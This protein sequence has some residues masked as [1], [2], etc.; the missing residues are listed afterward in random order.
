M[1][2]YAKITQILQAQKDEL[3]EKM[4]AQMSQDDI[5]LSGDESDQVQGNFLLSMQASMGARDIEKLNS[6]T[7]TLAKI[8]NG[9]YGKCEECGELISLKRLE[10]NPTFKLCIDCAEDLELAKRRN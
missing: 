4:R 1:E 5:D 9:D 10:F 2:R 8:A 7:V 6:I 3:I